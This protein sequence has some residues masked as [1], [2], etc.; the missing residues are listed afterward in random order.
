M[1]KHQ[2]QQ[3]TPVKDGGCAESRWNHNADSPGLPALPTT[4]SPD[5]A[6]AALGGP[7]GGACL[8]VGPGRW[9]LAHGPFRRA[10]DPP[11]H[12]TAFYRNDFAL[13]Q[14]NPWFIPAAS[15]ETT[16]PPAADGA[17]LAI[18]WDPLS[19]EG[20]AG[21]METVL[22]GL[23]DGRWRKAVLAVPETGRLTRGTPATI[24]R[25]ALNHRE[26]SVSWPFVF[27][28]AAGHGCAGMTPETLFTLR[29]RNLHTMALAGTA[30]TAEQDDF[31]HDTKQ[32]REHEIVADSLR[33]R[34]AAWGRVRSG[35]REVLNIGGLIH[36]ITRFEVELEKSPD[37]AELI[38]TL[39][40]TPALGILPRSAENLAS[41]HAWRRQLGVPDTFG[42]P[43]G[44][45]WNGGLQMVVA[46]R[47]LWWSPERVW[48]PA[49]CGIIDASAL[50]REWRELGLKRRWVKQAFGLDA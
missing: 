6:A 19:R 7:E 20:F 49:G 16:A 45:H 38:R 3:E 29:G 11:P 28:D 40:P 30:R 22:A 31:E 23:H 37:P 33:M 48:L 5:P 41:L 44:V 50:D 36:F 27:H 21:E 25:R 47:G 10:A 24:A 2:F 18:S 43:F 34:L 1:G 4:S 26:A 17:E 39:H 13:S 32:I 8:R 46:I 9:L 42:A 35:P 12:E 15:W 14:E